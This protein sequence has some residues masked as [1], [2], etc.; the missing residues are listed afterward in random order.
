MYEDMDK[1]I[2]DVAH[3]IFFSPTGSVTLPNKLLVRA[4]LEQLKIL[5]LLGKIAKLKGVQLISQENIPEMSTTITI[6][7]KENTN[8]D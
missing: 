7:Q 6:C 4:S 5:D 8:V 1:F 2:E 3:R